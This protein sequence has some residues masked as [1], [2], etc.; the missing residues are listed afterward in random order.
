MYVC[1]CINF[2]SLLRR[3][4]EC[5]RAYV[6]VCLY[7][8]VHMCVCV[9][10]VCLYACVCMQM[11]VCVCMCVCMYICV[12]MC[13]HMCMYVCMYVYLC[14]CMYYVLRRRDLDSSVWCIIHSWVHSYVACRSPR[15]YLSLLE[16][17]KLGRILLP[18]TLDWHQIGHT[19]HLPRQR[20]SNVPRWQRRQSADQWRVVQCQGESER[21]RV[22]VGV[23]LRVRGEGSR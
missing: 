9:V 2:G 10:Y 8:R 13:M 20:Q 12:P 11:C 1:V 17:Q 21:G 4:L 6:Y 7:V 18:S 23:K 16:R 5:V 19:V 14:V 3:L 22:K 15:D